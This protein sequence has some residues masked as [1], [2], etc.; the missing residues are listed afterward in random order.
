MVVDNLLRGHVELPHDFFG[1]MGKGDHSETPLLLTLIWSM[2]VSAMLMR[3]RE[4]LIENYK[5]IRDL[6]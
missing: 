5:Q 6:L 4:N 2:L 1:W 3:R